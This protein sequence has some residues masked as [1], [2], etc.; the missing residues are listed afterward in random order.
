VR[1]TRI[2]QQRTIRLIPTARQKPPVLEKLVASFGH[3]ADLEELEAMTSG[4]LMAERSGLPG[5]AAADMAHDYGYSYINAAFAYARPRG[6]R[7]STHRWGAWYGA[8][9]A[10]TGLAEVAYHLTRE[11][12]NVGVFHNVT[13]Y[14][15]LVCDI[16]AEFCD[17]R[18][19]E[20]LPAC[21]DPDG[22][23]GYAAGQQL[24]SELR[25]AGANGIV[26]PSVRRP[27][28]T[29]FVAFWPGLIQS[30]QHGAVWELVWA[31]SPE[32]KVRKV[33]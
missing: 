25:E 24:A 8:F 2:R 12:K 23:R 10:E 27:G 18:G 19:E 32:P 4:R 15:E 1:L 17:L 26:Y 13:R 6:S 22:E 29:C 7:F 16:D 30:F 33:G 28:G 21:L 14:V 11:L 3:R 31:G 20:P 9:E 5:L